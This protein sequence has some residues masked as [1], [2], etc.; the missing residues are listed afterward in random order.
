MSS[1]CALA[2]RWALLIS[3]LV[4]LSSAHPDTKYPPRKA[5]GKASKAARSPLARFNDLVV[6][7]TNAVPA[8][9][10]SSPLECF[11]VAE[12]VLTPQGPTFRDGAH[13]PTQ[14][15]A[16]IGEVAGHTVVLFEHS[17][18]NSYGAPYVGRLIYL[19]TCLGVN[20]SQC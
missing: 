9:A 18:A 4:G 20:R 5:A 12:P 8:V 11:Q 16:S 6:E 17:F 7:G 10:A 15:L 19:Y 1:I 14:D 13:A 2:M 3:L